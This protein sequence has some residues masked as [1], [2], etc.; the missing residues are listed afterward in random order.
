[1]E[2]RGNAQTEDT[3]MKKTYL[4]PETEFYSFVNESLLTLSKSADGTIGND[5]ENGTG[6]KGIEEI[7]DGDGFIMEAKH[8]NF[9]IWE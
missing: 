5:G 8:N 2:D 4:K 1:M 6:T 9:N 3:E 7:T